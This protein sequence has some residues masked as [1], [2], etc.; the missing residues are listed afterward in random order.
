MPHREIKKSRRTVTGRNL[1]AIHNQYRVHQQLGS[2]RSLR[3]PNRRRTS[4]LA[5]PC[6]VV[7]LCQQFVI[8]GATHFD[9]RYMAMDPQ[10]TVRRYARHCRYSAPTP[11]RSDS[12]S[13]RLDASRS[14]Q[15]RQKDFDHLSRQP[16][17]PHAPHYAAICHREIFCRR[18]GT[19]YEKIMPSDMCTRP[20]PY[21]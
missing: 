10:R 9:S 20:N 19:L 12:E 16:L 1:S 13:R 2:G 8:M 4:R 6:S 11:A 17:H 3:R 15:M 18:T 21:S 7:S 5:R 14:R